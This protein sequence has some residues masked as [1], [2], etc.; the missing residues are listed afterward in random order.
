[1]AE[2]LG[3]RRDHVPDPVHLRPDEEDIGH[4]DLLAVG[5]ERLNVQVFGPET[6]HPVPEEVVAIFFNDPRVS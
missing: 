2:S 5:T 4:E 6:E 3:F 1:V